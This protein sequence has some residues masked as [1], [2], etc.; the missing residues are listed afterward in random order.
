MHA[1]KP[2]CPYCGTTEGL[3]AIHKGCGSVPAE[4]TCEGCFTAQDDGPCFDDLRPVVNPGMRIILEWTDE[5]TRLIE[6][7][8]AANMASRH[9]MDEGGVFGVRMGTSGNAY[10]IKRNAESVR[11]YPQPAS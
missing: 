8:Q 11:V 10:S 7:V 4:Y 2:E 6:Q 9:G 3:R 5:Y 1:T